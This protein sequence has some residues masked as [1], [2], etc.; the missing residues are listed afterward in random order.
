LPGEDGAAQPVAGAGQADDQAI[1]HQLVVAHAFHIGDVLDAHRLGGQQ[2]GPQQQRK[3]E[4]QGRD[5][6]QAERICRH[7]PDHSALLL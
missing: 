4:P 2:G 3:T 5:F 1:A 6:H 7:C